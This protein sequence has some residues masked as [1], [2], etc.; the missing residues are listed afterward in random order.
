MRYALIHWLYSNFEANLD[1]R[2]FRVVE[3]YVHITEKCHSMESVLETLFVTL[4][5]FL[6]LVNIRFTDFQ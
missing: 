1:W 4:P 5:L 3:K 2:F 6:L